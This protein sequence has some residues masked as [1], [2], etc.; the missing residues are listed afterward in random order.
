MISERSVWTDADQGPFHFL[1]RRVDNEQTRMVYKQEATGGLIM[2][3]RLDRNTIKCSRVLRQNMLVQDLGLEQIKIWW[4]NPPRNASQTPDRCCRLFHQSRHPCDLWGRNLAME[5][6]HYLNELHFS[7][8]CTP[9]KLP[10]STAIHLTSWRGS[11]WSMLCLSDFLCPT[12]L[13]FIFLF[14]IP[15]F[16]FTLCR[17]FIKIFMNNMLKSKIMDARTGKTRRLSPPLSGVMV[18]KWQRIHQWDYWMLVIMSWHIV[19]NMNV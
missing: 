4:C 7:N 8:P 15:F 13:V 3:Q 10:S 18:M 17:H 19:S 11:Q 6:I 12:I 2:H 9:N 1:C 16:T 14:R 5:V